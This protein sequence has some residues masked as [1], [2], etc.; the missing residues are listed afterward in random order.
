MHSKPITRRASVLRVAFAAAMAIAAAGTFQ[1]SLA[2]AL[3]VIAGSASDAA[4]AKGP[5]GL[6]DM[7][8]RGTFRAGGRQCQR[9]R[10]AQD[11]HRGRGP[12]DDIGAGPPDADPMREFCCTSSSSSAACRPDPLPIQ[13]EGS[14]FIRP[15]RRRDPNQRHVVNGADEVVVKLTDQREYVAK[16]LGADKLSDVAC[17]RS[18]RAT[19][20]S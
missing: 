3:P 15:C 8:D 20:P 4:L 9:Q 7:R 12:G 1:R 16:V 10:L 5:G 18:M 14:G 11:F 13:G 2:V 17:S 19:S 6:P